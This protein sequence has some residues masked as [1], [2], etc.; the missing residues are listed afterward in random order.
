MIYFTKNR[1]IKKESITANFVRTTEAFGFIIKGIGLKI[2]LAF[3]EFKPD[4]VHI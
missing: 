1:F 4:V 3:I 2:C